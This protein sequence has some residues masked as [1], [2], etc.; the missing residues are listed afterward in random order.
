MCLLT[1][2]PNFT[3][4][5]KKKGMETK[6]LSLTDN[7]KMT[8]WDVSKLRLGGEMFAAENGTTFR[9]YSLGFNKG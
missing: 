4:Q 6:T 9:K 1:F 2:F 5:T 7:S 3:L 8:E